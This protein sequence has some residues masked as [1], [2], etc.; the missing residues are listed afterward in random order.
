[1]LFSVKPDY[2]GHMTFIN[3]HKV[4]IDVLRLIGQYE[5]PQESDPHRFDGVDPDVVDAILQDEFDNRQ[6][7]HDHIDDMINSWDTDEN[8]ILVALIEEKAKR[9]S[10]AKRIR[11]LVAY[12]REIIS[13][14]RPTLASLAEVMDMTISGVRGL[15]GPDD[16][17][18]ARELLGGVDQRLYQ[19]LLPLEVRV[20]KI[21]DYIES[22]F[23]MNNE[24]LDDTSRSILE[25]AAL[26]T[27]LPEEFVW[28]DLEGRLG[29]TWPLDAM[30]DVLK[31]DVFLF[32][33]FGTVVEIDGMPSSIM[34][35]ESHSIERLRSFRN[36]YYG[37]KRTD[38]LRKHD[39]AIV[40][41]RIE[42]LLQSNNVYAIAEKI[43]ELANE[44]VT[45]QGE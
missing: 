44:A 2:N 32:I 28:G 38:D 42:S 20:R 8:H 21:A 5:I 18:A 12:S 30:S 6:G 25:M 11:L 19:Q 14:N 40:T 9:D 43:R 22:L 1:V 36:Q 31:R 17:I 24:P 29:E 15:Y 4:G 35:K 45:E 39:F 16:V 27:I 33:V 26:T 10:A 7:Y 41:A 34:K 23:L 3:S 13:G 37:T